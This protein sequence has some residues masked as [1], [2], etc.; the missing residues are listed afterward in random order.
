MRFSLWQGRIWQ[1]SFLSYPLINYYRDIKTRLLDSQA[2]T[3]P[4]NDSVKVN[5]PV[6][7]STPGCCT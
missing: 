7:Q 1:I 6:A 5:Y 3:A 2:D 4:A